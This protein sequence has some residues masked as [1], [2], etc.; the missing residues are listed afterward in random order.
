MKPLI[1]W[2]S[3]ILAVLLMATPVLAADVTIHEDTVLPGLDALMQDF[4]DDY[5]LNENNFSMGYCYTGTG[6]TYY[7]NK[8]KLL[9]GA[10]TYKLPLNMCISEGIDAGKFSENDYVAGNTLK[11]AQYLSMVH[12]DN[13]SS[14]ALQKYLVGYAYGYYYAYREAISCY[15]G[16]FLEKEIP[17]E[18]YT[19][20]NFS[21]EFMI[22]TLVYLYNHSEDFETILCYMKE[23]QPGSYFKL[24]VDEYEIAHKYG[25]LNG[26]VNDVGIIYTPTPFLLAVFTKNVNGEEVLGALCKRLCDYT[27]GLE[28]YRE[29][30][31]TE[32]REE[33]YRKAEIT[34]EIRETATSE[35]TMV[36]VKDTLC[37]T[38][39][40]L[41]QTIANHFLQTE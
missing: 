38:A 2:L 24:Y 41:M 22:N 29:T 10:S 34:A 12:S 23:A 9:P 15:S 20:N 26:S 17:A 28:E 11:H 37:C 35:K 1:R 3:A 4:C 27:V 36:L 40:L 30:Y 5:G 32:I 39:D 6:E 31:R 19:G 25:F 8:E 21:P 7:Y 14:Q 33:A 18:Y 16:T 13:P